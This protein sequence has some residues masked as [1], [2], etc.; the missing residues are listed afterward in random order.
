MSINV[1]RLATYMLK[2]R[3][4]CG[5][6]DGENDV[7]SYLSVANN[8]RDIPTTSPRKPEYTDMALEGS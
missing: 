1:Q 8:V 4:V 5:Y 3:S 6:K 2:V 7:K